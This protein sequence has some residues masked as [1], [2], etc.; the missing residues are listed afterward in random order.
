MRVHLYPCG[1]KFARE[2]YKDTIKKLVSKETIL[3]FSQEISPVS[4]LTDDHF[5]CWGVTNG[6]GNINLNKWNKMEKGDVC[7]MYRDKAFFSA[8]KIVTKFKNKELAEYL[9]KTNDEGETW[10]NIFLIDEV[11]KINIPIKSFIDLMGYK[12][13]FVVQGYMTYE[14]DISELI[15]EELDL[16]GWNSPFYTTDCESEEDKK[17]RIQEALQKLDKTDSK[18]HTSK[19]RIEQQLLREFHMGIK[20]TTCSL[21]H[22]TYPNELVVAG[23]I[24]ERHKIKDE[25]IRKDPDV[26]M[27]VCKL[28][29]DELFEKGFIVVDETGNIVPDIKNITSQPLVQFAKQYEGKKCL[30]FNEKTKKFFNERYGR[31]IH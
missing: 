13:K 18:S 24:W 9:W 21:C 7:L 3:N 17:K 22:K 1:D 31:K 14:D 4:N 26:V 30:H 5:A 12:E 27:P 10:E 23:H 8:G 19:R 29:C 15:V 28:G 20:E 11:K 16:I 25:E 6:K 2:H